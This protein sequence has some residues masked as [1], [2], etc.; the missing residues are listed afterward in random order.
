MTP[1]LLLTLLPGDRPLTY[2]VCESVPRCSRALKET[3]KNDVTG[4]I[5]QQNAVSIGGQT[6]TKKKSLV[7]TLLH[8][9]PQTPGARKD[10]MTEPSTQEIAL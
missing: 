6:T 3:D 1:T 8:G 10:R 5:R 2:P 7:Q 9:K 4:S